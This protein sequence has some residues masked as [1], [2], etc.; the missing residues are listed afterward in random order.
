VSQIIELDQN[1]HN[2]VVEILR[3]SRLP[4]ADIDLNRQFFV[5]YQS[6][7]RLEGIGALEIHGSSALVRSMAVLHNGQNKGVGS[8]ILSRLIQ[9]AREKNLK[10]LYLLTETAEN[11]FAR[12]GFEKTD[13]STVPDAILNSEEFK[14]LCPDSAI[15]MMYRL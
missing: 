12:N 13:R 8:S 11:F 6:A 14:N 15:C 1:H 5:G 2:T 10:D 7:T 9:Q 4:E 3:N